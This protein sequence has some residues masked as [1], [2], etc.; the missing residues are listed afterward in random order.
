MISAITEAVEKVTG[1]SFEEFTGPIQK[2]DRY[3]ARL[4]FSHN[5]M[6]MVKLNYRS[7]AVMVNRNPSTVFRYQNFYLNEIKY[8]P[9]FRKLARLTEEKL[10]KVY[11]SNTVSN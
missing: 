7:V 5:C 10:A 9:D 11:Q 4:I 8:N 2:R 1:I 3:F 6:K